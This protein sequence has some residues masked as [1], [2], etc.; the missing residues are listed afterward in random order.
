MPVIFASFD[1][2]CYESVADPRYGVAQLRRFYR[3]FGPGAEAYNNG[4]RTHAMKW[5]LAKPASD[6]P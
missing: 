2:K 1:A 5:G 6:F 3:G 4:S